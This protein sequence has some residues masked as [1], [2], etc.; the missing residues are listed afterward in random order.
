MLIIGA[1]GFAKE[2]LEVAIENN[3]FKIY[4]FDNVSN[5]IDHVL[6]DKYEILKNDN[7]VFT[8]F[9]TDNSFSIGIGNS[10][11]R[12]K[13]YDKFSSMGGKI[14]SLVSTKSHIGSFSTIIE[15]GANILQGSV[16]TNGCTVGKC[17]LVNPNVTISHDVTIGDFVEIAPGANITG[18]VSIDDFTF[19][20]ANA[21]ILPRIKIGKNVIVGAGAVVTKDVPDGFTVVGIPAKPIKK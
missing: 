7:E 4:F 11:L 1:K 16:I 17:V 18:G 8:L 19:V 5:D 20:G 10:F 9:K 12:K 15:K 14:T 6:Y 3:Y 21:V 13:M 2:L